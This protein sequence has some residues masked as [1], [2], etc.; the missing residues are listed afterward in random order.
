MTQATML[1]IL[2][3]RVRKPSNTS[4]SAGY[5]K[6]FNTH[7]SMCYTLQ[8]VQPT[9]PFCYCKVQ[10]NPSSH[11]MAYTKKKKNSSTHTAGTKVYTCLFPFNVHQD[12]NILSLSK[13]SCAYSSH[14]GTSG[15]CQV[16]VNC[17]ITTSASPPTLSRHRAAPL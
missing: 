1:D 4:M 13:L 3:S 12:T 5:Q 16:K 9:L 8:R 10:T 15:C 14:P 17:Q 6:P 7:H 11:G 2:L